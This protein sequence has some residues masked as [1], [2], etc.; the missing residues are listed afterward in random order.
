[1]PRGESVRQVPYVNL[2]AQFA[3]DRDA[4]MSAVETVLAGGMWVG[5]DEGTELEAALCEYTGAGHAVAVSSGTDALIVAL[6]A[7]DI[8]PGDDVI[9][10]PNSF[11]SSAAAVVHVGARP[12][13]ADVGDDQNVDPA[14]VAAAVT[15][16]TRAVMPVHLTGRVCA[17]EAIGEIAHRHRLHVIE[18]AAQAFGSRLDGRCA[19]TFGDIGCFSAH[20]LKNLNAMGDAGFAL[21]DDAGLAERMRRFRNN[22]L[23]DRDTVQEWGFV[24]R[25]DAVQ[26]AILLRRLDLLDGVIARRRANAARYRTRLS[27]THVFWPPCRDS[28]FNTFHTFV[29]QGD[30]RDDLRQH[31]AAHGIG[32]AIHYPVPIHLQPAA[33]DLGYGVG[34]FP[35]A[36]RQA[37]RILSLPVH[38]LLANEDI[39][40][41]ADTVNGFYR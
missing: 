38:Q 2:A 11:I 9:V 34:A 33:A 25:M 30:R 21:T 35:A 5:G 4:I 3:A 26:A 22:G 13:F 41:V 20:P 27:P 17:M 32:S 39:D 10:P 8:G 7:L 6:K 1:M 16:R 15:P 31:L 40:Y 28:E 29:V 18:D 14:T 37:G 12:V 19:G 36:E 24:D 23:A